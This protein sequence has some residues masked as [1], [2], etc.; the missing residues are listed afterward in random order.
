MALVISRFPHLG[1]KFSLDAIVLLKG[2]LNWAHC[3]ICDCV[4]Q[5]SILLPSSKNCQKYSIIQQH[6][7]R[8]LLNV[9]NRTSWF[10]FIASLVYIPVQYVSG[11]LPFFLFS[12]W[13]VGGKRTLSNILRFFCTILCP[14]IVCRC[15]QEMRSENAYP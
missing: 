4:R 11:L 15:F 7:L 10:L 5:I 12:S 1:K 14:T 9:V 13:W 2:L 3:R 6:W 8:M